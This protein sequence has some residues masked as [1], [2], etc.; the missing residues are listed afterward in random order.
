MER[1]GREAAIIM[2]MQAE[3]TIL[4]SPAT[5]TLAELAQIAA[6][7]F[8]FPAF[9]LRKLQIPSHERAHL[10]VYPGILFL[11]FAA[12]LGYHVLTTP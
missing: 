8:A 1:E 11:V 12:L 6:I 7:Y 10:F 2:T 3:V 5:Y 4:R 9:G